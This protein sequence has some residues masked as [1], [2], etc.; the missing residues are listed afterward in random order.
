MI[1]EKQIYFDIDAHCSGKSTAQMHLTKCKIVFTY[2]KI[3][4]CSTFSKRGVFG[5]Y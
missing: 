5:F 1:T 4:V 3:T 2:L